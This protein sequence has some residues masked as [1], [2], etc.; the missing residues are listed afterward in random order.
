MNAVIWKPQEKQ[1]AF[2]ARP[3]FEALYGGAAGGGKSDALVIEALRQVH[4]PHYKG[5]ILR[6]TFPQLAELIDKTLNYY[7]RAFPKAKYNDSKHV[8]TFPSG[9]KIIFGA[10]QYTKDRTKYQGQAYDFIAFDELTHFTYEEYSYMFSRCRPNGP[11]TRCYIRS[12]ANPGGVGHGWVKERFIT[13]GAPMTPIRSDVNITFPD[14]HTETRRRSRIFVPA[15]VYDNQELLRN[16][17]DYLVNLASL[18]KADREAL[19]DGNWDSFTGQVFMEWR[20]DSEH[21]RDRVNTH[22]I[23]PFLIPENWSVWCALDW[24]YSRPFSVGWFA[25]DQ[26]R[27][28]YHIREYYGCTGTPNEGVKL[29]PGAVAREI[30]R[31]ESEDPNLKGRTIHRVGDPAIWGSDGTESIGSLME[32][33]RVY[34][35]R[36]DHARIDGKMQVHHRLAFDENGRP[37]LYVFETCRNFIRTVPNLVYSESNAEDVDTNGEDHCLVGD[38]QVWTDTGK[39]P[40]RAL[41]GTSG[42]VLSSD[43]NYHVFHDVRRTQRQVQV[44][45]VELEDGSTVTATA[46]HRFLLADGTWKRLDEL[47][48]GDDLK[49]MEENT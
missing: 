14:G 21:Y 41:V 23:E 5:L 42:Q 3:E 43:G 12:T 26:D 11:G 27:R 10:M 29:E 49:K 46:N 17:P 44:F 48:P 25:V 8:W 2:M 47:R 7:P 35:E 28:L 37:M 9:A 15:R 6:K 1:A 4:I 32:R 31:I 30:K 20:N 18:P 16:N 13:A 39:K 34:F 45:T 19:L 40:I 38:T 33:E 24:G 22:V 36:G